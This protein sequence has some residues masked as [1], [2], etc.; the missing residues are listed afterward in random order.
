VKVPAHYAVV[1]LSFAAAFVCY[2]DRVNISVAILAMQDQF[3]WQ[4]GVKGVVLSSFFVGYLLFQVP[5]GWLAKRFGGRLV[6]GAAV[7]WWSAFTVLTPAAA[8]V[9][10][11]ALVAARIGMGL[12]EGA[13]FPAAYGL[14]GQHVPADSRAR[15]VALLLSGVP[16]GTLFALSTTGWLVTNYGWPSAFYLFGGAGLLWAAAWFGV[17]EK[18]PRA[19]EEPGAAAVPWGPLLRSPAVWALIVNHFCSN[20]GLYLV[21]AWLPSFFRDAHHLS[22]TN[23]GLFSAAPWLTMFVVIN[24]GGWFA[25][26]LVRRGVEVTAVRK[27]MQV[28]GL[29]GSALFLWLAQGAATAEMALILMCSAM[30][31]LGLTWSGF[32][33]NHMDIAPEYAGVLMGISNTAG[34]IPGVIGVALTGWLVQTTG[35]YTSAFLMAVAVNLFGAVIWLLFAQGRRI[36]PAPPAQGVVQ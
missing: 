10:L 9:S 2:I 21:L 7:L 19:V 33:P 12:G 3:G 1:G 5:G 6:L 22:I 32:G 17:I 24:L 27:L 11:P 8:L 14:F 16:L 23:A 26:R 34:T 35:T 15:A 28:A 30:G 29:A 31:A 20:W 4:A 13:M 25:D 36:L 18:A